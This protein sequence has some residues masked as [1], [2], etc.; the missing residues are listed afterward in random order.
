[1][2]DDS[3]I[4]GVKQLNVHNTQSHTLPGAN[5]NNFNPKSVQQSPSKECKIDGFPS[6][7]D[8]V[9]AVTT[10]PRESRSTKP[11]RYCYRTKAGME[12]MSFHDEN[13]IGDKFWR[14]LSEGEEIPAGV[15]YENCYGIIEI[16]DEIVEEIDA[17]M[18]TRRKPVEQNE[19]E[20]EGSTARL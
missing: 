13:E 12:I 4:R 5:P 9:N 8:A 19:T 15:P 18:I 20:K 2:Q 6:K 1:M 3:L 10:K 14:E 7:Q 17:S 16:E 11:R